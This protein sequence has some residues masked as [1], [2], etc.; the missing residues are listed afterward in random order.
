VNEELRQT[1]LALEVAREQILEL[2]RT[3]EARVELR[4]TALNATNQELEAFSS[5]IAHDLRTPLLNITGFADLLKETAGNQLQGDS[6]EF[7]DRIIVSARRMNDLID[8]VLAFAH[9]DREHLNRAPIDLEPV[10]D[11]AL[12]ALRPQSDGRNIIWQ[13][14]HLPSASAD[15]ALLRQVFVNLIGNAI[16]YTRARNPARIEIGWRKGRADEIVIFVRDNGVGFDMQQAT[17]LFGMFRRLTGAEPFEGIGIGLANAHRI[18][19]RHGGRIW[20][21]SAPGDGA[22]FSFSLPRSDLRA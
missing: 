1:R 13:R 6:S 21:E 18:I 12:E 4:T 2:N 9:L 3:L 15:P 5:S 10:L 20:A 16:K 14:T 8:A 19:T 11:E 17:E 22:T 7:L